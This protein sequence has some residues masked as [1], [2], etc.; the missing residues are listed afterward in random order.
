[1]LA[2]DK[3]G[4]WGKKLY[5]TTWRSLMK[6][7]D[8]GRGRRLQPVLSK[9]GVRGYSFKRSEEIRGKPESGDTWKKGK[10]N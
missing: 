8:S 9:G 6:Y 2:K 7:G 4:E 5:S 10:K 3:P 1:M